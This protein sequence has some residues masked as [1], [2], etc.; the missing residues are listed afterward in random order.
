MGDLL[1][2]FVEEE[3]QRQIQENYPYLRHPPC[4]YAEVIKVKDNQGIYTAVLKILD[5]NKN[6]DSRF[7]EIPN[8]TTEIPIKAGDV[9]VSVLMYGECDPFI[10][11]RCPQCK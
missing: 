8:V 3:F 4:V 1:K 2:K 11:G 7:S 5:K 10:I 9:V 6:K